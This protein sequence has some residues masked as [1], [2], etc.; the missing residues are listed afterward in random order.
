M[1]KLEP[2][3]IDVAIN[4]GPHLGCTCHVMSLVL[5]SSTNI[6]H[7]PLEKN[8]GKIVNASATRI[9][10]WSLVYCHLTSNFKVK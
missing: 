8:K 3:E 5:G 1:V 9:V 4:I 10:V 2:A 7:E 6:L